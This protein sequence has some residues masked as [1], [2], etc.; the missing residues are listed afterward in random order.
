MRNIILAKREIYHIY[1]R[2][3]DKRKIFLNN[4]DYQRFVN[5]LAVFNDVKN[6]NGRH[7]NDLI[8]DQNK[9]PLVNIIAYCLMPNHFHLLIEQ[10]TD[11]GI[12]KFLQ[13]LTTSYTMY[14]N[15]KNSRTGALIQGVFKRS[16]IKTSPRLLEMSKYIHS[17]PI[18]ILRNNKLTDAAVKKRLVAYAWSS[19]PDYIGTRKKSTIIENTKI[20]LDQFSSQKAYADFILGET[21]VGGLT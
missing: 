18:K 3:V 1:N 7:F 12:T 8:N 4:R 10:R 21:S 14:F 16:H 6:L 9:E 11:N 2:G 5:S 13:K 20:I 19:L 17:N 15:I